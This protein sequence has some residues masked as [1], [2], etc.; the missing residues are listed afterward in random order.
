MVSF[1]GLDK[2]FPVLQVHFTF[3]NINIPMPVFFSNLDRPESFLGEISSSSSPHLSCQ[4]F[5]RK[6]CTTSTSFRLLQD[7]LSLKI[8]KGVLPEPKFVNHGLNQRHRNLLVPRF[9]CL[10]DLFSQFMVIPEGWTARVSAR[11]T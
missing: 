6:S 9:P 1:W 2:G 8:Q 7:Y 11:T 5:R 4:P 10:L 3:L